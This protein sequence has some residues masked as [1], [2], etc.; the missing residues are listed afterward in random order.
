MQTIDEAARKTRVTAETDILVVGGGPAGINAA[1][2]AKRLGADV[3]IVEKGGFFG[4]TM[5]TVTLGNICGPYTVKG[6]DVIPVVQGIPA[7][8]IQ[9]LQKCGGGSLPRI[10]KGTATI[11][12]DILSMKLICDEMV[13]EA[14]VNVLFHA[15]AT[16]IVMDDNQ[17]KGIIVETKAGREALLAK[18]VIDATGD[19]DVSARAGVPFATPPLDQLQFSTLTFRWSNVDTSKYSL[20]S[21]EQMAEC[22][23]Q[24]VQA[25]IDLPRTHGTG[26]ITPRAGEVHCNVTRVGKDGRA[27]NPLDPLEL[28]YAELEGRRQVLLY[29]EAFRRFVPGFENAYVND[30][31]ALIGIRESRLIKG[32]YTLQKDDVMHCRKFED[33]IACSAWPLEIH[34]A[35]RGTEWI[36]LPEGEHYNIPLR[37]L[38]PVGVDNLLVA[39]RSLSATHEAHAS[40]R[41]GG[42][43]MALGQAAGT[44]AAVALR[45]ETTVRNVD[46][47]KVQSELLRAGALIK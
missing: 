28:T 39:G 25:G 47:A 35:D 38:I 30:S 20:V 12:F 43:S 16:D 10:W 6:S 46:V 36:W 33:G 44:A 32:E 34:G 3:T 29:Q 37:T 27:I 21:R 17:L 23:E 19:A 14:G 4:G 42:V 7:E 5:T 26:H 41:A 2:A 24:A 22:L 1:I 11:A 15:L 9:R 31:G 45:Q 18:I 8:L 40:A 13:T